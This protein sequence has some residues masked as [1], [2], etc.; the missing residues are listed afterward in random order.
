MY[1]PDAAA[2]ITRDHQLRGCQVLQDAVEDSWSHTQAAHNL[3]GL[4]YP[5]LE[6]AV[7]AVQ[8]IRVW[9]Q[10]G[11]RRK[12][13]NLKDI[14]FGLLTACQFPGW[15]DTS[16]QNITHYSGKNSSWYL[17][18]VMKHVH[19]WSSRF[20]RTLETPVTYKSRLHSIHI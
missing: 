14:H 18:R 12:R 4:S 1:Y 3:P 10:N 20:I 17:L 2:T 15:E 5:S 11:T 8:E 6:I 19:P 9:I 13:G 7:I 16:G